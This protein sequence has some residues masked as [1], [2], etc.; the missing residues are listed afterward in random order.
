MSTDTFDSDKKLR[1]DTE[2]VQKLIELRDSLWN[3]R[4]HLSLGEQYVV[5]KIN[6]C[7]YE[8]KEKK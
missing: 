5:F 6:S 7:L 2:I 1:T 4:L 3:Q 8:P